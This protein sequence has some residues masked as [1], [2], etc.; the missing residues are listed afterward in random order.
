MDQQDR[1]AQIGK[2]RTRYWQA[3]DAGSAVV[4]LHGIGCSVL[5]WRGNMAQLAQKHRVYALDL[6]GS[7]LTDK[8]SDADYSIRGHAQFVLDFMA[9]QGME[10]AHLVGNSLGG[11]VALECALMAP[12]RVASMVLVDPAGVDRETHINM[13][14][15]AAPVV[16]ELLT[17]PSRFGLR[18]LWKLAFYNPAFVTDA[19][20][21]DKFN[22]ASLPGAQA[23]FLKTLRSFLAFGGFPAE[24]V[25]ALHSAMPSIQAPALV[26]WGKQDRLLPVRQ[27]DTLKRLLP[28]VEV[29]LYD[30]CGHAP[31]VECAQNFNDDV[32]RYWAALEAA[33]A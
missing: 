22:F 1:F 32:L 11:R 18:M 20:V 31:M 21:E 5:E 33:G 10:R 6:L 27:A 23:A 8:P 30:R 26:L 25:A 19:V 16:G 14:L 12:V 3:G 15:A 2:V 17:R 29:K 24:Q 13:R 4:L 28:N 7:G 9:S